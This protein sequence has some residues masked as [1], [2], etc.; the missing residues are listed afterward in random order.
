MT[1]INNSTE[2]DHSKDSN[3]NPLTQDSTEEQT[4]AEAL[5]VKRRKGKEYDYKKVVGEEIEKRKNNMLALQLTDQKLVDKQKEIAKQDHEQ[6][7][8]E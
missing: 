7:Y 2:R 1:N 6:D 5:A 8:S 3:Q 4:A